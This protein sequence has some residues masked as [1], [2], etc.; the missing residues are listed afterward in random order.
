MTKKYRRLPDGELAIMQI[1]WDSV[2]P[3]SRPVIE[4]KANQSRP[5]A[6]TT[7]LTLLARLAEKGFV[8]VE[9][10]GRGNLY[11]PL[12][13]RRDYMAQ[14]SRSVLDRLFGGSLSSFALALSDSGVSREELEEL[15]RLLEEDKL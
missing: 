7:I 14:E 2:G 9:K 3:M 6:S 4:E 10:A 8:A 1:L 13:S 11:A 15:R 5:Q 12:V